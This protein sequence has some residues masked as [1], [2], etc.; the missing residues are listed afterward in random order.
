MDAS[1]SKAL[2]R[3]ERR[4][5]P[6]APIYHGEFFKAA[7]RS[8][9]GPVRREGGPLSIIIFTFWISEAL[10]KKLGVRY[11]E[12]IILKMEKIINDALRRVIDVVI[13]DAKAV[14][15]LCRRLHG[16]TLLLRWGAFPRSSKI[17]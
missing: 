15:V 16:K 4:H 17:I 8:G 13:K 10:E 5:L 14:M 12:R 1:R 3:R 2:R 6:V 11:V 7:I 9:H